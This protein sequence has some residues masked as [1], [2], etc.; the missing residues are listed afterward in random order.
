[1][2]C[3]GWSGPGVPWSPHRLC[4]CLAGLDQARALGLSWQEGPPTSMPPGG[5]AQA[6]EGCSPQSAWANSWLC[7]GPRQCPQPAPVSMGLGTPTDLSL[8]CQDSCQPHRPPPLGQPH[9]HLISR[10][11][12]QR[13]KGPSPCP[14]DS[15]PSLARSAQVWRCHPRL[16]AGRPQ[17]LQAAAWSQ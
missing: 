7:L 9:K 2:A 1:M 12:Y 6:L 15:S 10:M 11:G 14:A 13:Q 16:Q 5:P 17:P 3:S 4:C 8:R